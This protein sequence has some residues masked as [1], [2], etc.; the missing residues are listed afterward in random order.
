M[1]TGA[2]SQADKVLRAL[3]D[4]VASAYLGELAE[5]PAGT[6]IAQELRDREDLVEIAASTGCATVGELCE[7]LLMLAV[8]PVGVS[9][10]CDDTLARVA[11]TFSKAVREMDDGHQFDGPARAAYQDMAIAA[12][13]R[14]FDDDAGTV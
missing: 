4:A 14:D 6:V 12:A 10:L 5:Y 2:D 13:E 8:R 9:R 11:A 7:Y 1:V 3:L